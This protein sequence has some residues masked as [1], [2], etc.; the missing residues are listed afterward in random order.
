[1]RGNGKIAREEIREYVVTPT[2]KGTNKELVRFEGGYEKDGKMIPYS[3]PG[4]E[5]KDVDIDGELIDELA[6][7]LAND[8][9]SRDGIAAELFPLTTLEQRKYS[10]ALKGTREFRGRPVYR[11]VFEPRSKSWDE[12]DGTP[13][14]GEILVDREDYQP[15][16]VNTHLARGLPIAVRTLLGTNLKGLG[17]QLRYERFD[18]GLWFPVSYGTEFEVKA[19]FFYKRLIAISL[20]NKGFQRAQVAARV[21]YEQ[22]LKLEKNLKVPEVPPPPPSVPPRW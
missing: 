7:D 21:T 2:E 9:H 18:E 16:S 10:F 4:F 19:L 12:D 17:F 1:M 14:A 22:P 20:S 6:E 11:I 15:V 3:A 5:Y 8:D 13:W